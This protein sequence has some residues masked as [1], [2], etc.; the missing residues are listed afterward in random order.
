MALE[1]K[2]AELREVDVRMRLTAFGLY[3]KTVILGENM[4]DLIVAPIKGD[5]E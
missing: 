4:F 5:V 1:R 3:D 2:P